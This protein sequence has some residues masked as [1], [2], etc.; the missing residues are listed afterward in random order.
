[1]SDLEPARNG[2]F[3][4]DIHPP[5]FWGSAGTV[6]LFVVVSLLNLDQMTQVFKDVLGVI[7]ESG[8]WFLVLCV[9]IYLAVVLYLL[10]SRHGRVRLGGDDARPDYSYW[11]WLSMLFSAGMGIGLMFWSVA[12][13]I[14]HYISPPWGE[15][16]TAEA[17]QLAM[18]ITFFHWGLHA[19]GLYG[20]MALALAYFAYNHGLPLTVRSAFYP[21]LGE[22]IHGWAGNII[23]VLATVATLFGLATSLGLGAQQVNAGFAYLFGIPQSVT[24]QVIL[25]AVITAMAT[26]S[27]VL[28]VDKGIRRLSQVNVILASLLLLFVLIAGPTHYLLDA[29]VQNIGIYVQNLPRLSFWTETYQGT[30][31]QHGWTLFYWAWWIAWSPF[32]GIFIARVSRGR[33]VREFVSA[34][35]IVPT[36][37]TFVW[38]TVFGNAAL[39]VELFG[40]GG[41]T[42]AVQADVA[43]ALFK[44][45]EHYPLTSITVTLAVCIVITF[46]VTSSDSAS[47]V[48][49]IITAGGNLNPPKIQRVFWASMEGML[50]AVLLM[51]GG[52]LALQTAV[53]ATGLPFAVI[54]LML[55]FSLLRA[56]KADNKVAGSK[57]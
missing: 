6:V 24:V 54:L 37:A 13:P 9:N 10:F 42:A 27:V 15:A 28:G 57:G 51:G 39:Y 4:F 46:F 48:V 43:V 25:I 14:N 56:L 23:D 33:T 22:R 52:L 55:G 11:G 3:K 35:L 44:L 45:L 50:A 8:G 12:E 36:L 31:W 26:V 41:I 49:D 17:A 19:W 20:L 2:R 47:L 40:P 34:I 7:T 1:M 38:L 18:G 21:L 30:V 29:L 53:V 32:V 5:V 16:Q